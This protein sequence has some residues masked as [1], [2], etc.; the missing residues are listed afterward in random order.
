MGGHEHRRKDHKSSRSGA[1]EGFEKLKKALEGLATAKGVS[2]SR[3]SAVAKL[4]AHYSKFYKH[5][6]HDI[7]VFL[8]KAEVEHRLAG[9]YAVDAII[10]QSH[11]K[12]GS[13]DAYV[14]RFLIRMSDTIAAVKKVPEQFQPKVKH[15]IEEWQKRAIYTPRQIEDLGGREY[16]LQEE[17]SGNVT[18]RAS[19]GKLASLLS[20]IK[21]KKEE[22]DHASDQPGRPPY[23][24]AYD[25][26][27]RH[28]REDTA[29]YNHR[30]YDERR[31][32]D[33]RHDRRDVG[34]IMGGCTWCSNDR[35]VKKARGSRWGPSKMDNQSSNDR[36]APII[37]SLDRDG[38]YH[39]ES[40]RPGYG[41]PPG[42][43]RQGPL[44]QSPHGGPPR[45]EE[46]NRN[47]PPSHGSDTGWS[48]ENARSPQSGG[49]SRQNVSPY[50][51]GGMQRS[52]F[53]G[54]DDRRSPGNRIPG[55]SGEL[56][57]N[58]LAGRCTFGDRCWY[59]DDFTHM[60]DPQTASAAVGRSEMVDSKRKTVLCNNFPLGMCRFGDKCRYYSISSIDG[61][62]S[63]FIHF[64]GPTSDGGLPL[65]GPELD[66]SA[67]YPP[68]RP[69]VHGGDQSG[70]RW[71]PSPSLRQGMEL[72][73]VS[74]SANAPTPTSQARSYG[75]PQVYNEPHGDRGS[76]GGDSSV[77]YANAAA[78]SPNGHRL[79]PDHQAAL[80]APPQGY[81]GAYTSAPSPYGAASGSTYANQ[82]SPYPSGDQ[83]RNRVPGNVPVLPPPASG[84]QS[85]GD[86]IV[87]PTFNAKVVAD[88]DEGETVE[89]EFTL[90]Y[91]DE[92]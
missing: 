51:Q 80:G 25:T 61:I 67:R 88:D 26:T 65:W 28:Q 62:T 21:Q 64:N 50:D 13:K 5:V 8:W 44:L 33:Q 6:V 23:D 17:R 29:A 31:G 70:S 32:T 30:A 83:D 16:M 63:L 77:S 11:T 90:E 66:K 89:P 18:P 74:P 78:P 52:P 58:F 42:S 4:A 69:P 9:L 59:G 10:R 38:A 76:R 60:H 40:G 24:E 39:Q 55:T 57:R 86:Q 2:Q 35:D 85:Y 15:V 91:D 75:A 36:P 1:W 81:Q 84:S 79:P 43:S 82:G 14:K 12:N 87:A 54:S 56:C 7:E 46:W 45:H 37:T 19:P 92:D 47:A 68:P 27:D 20:I 3:I 41:P 72:I 73:G 48:H 71:Q 49:L 53:S 22:K 34:G